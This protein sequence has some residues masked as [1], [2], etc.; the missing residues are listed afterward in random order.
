[1][2]EKKQVKIGTLVD[3]ISAILN[4]WQLD[5]LFI[6]S[7]VE[8]YDLD[9]FKAVERATDI[10]EKISCNDVIYWLLQQKADKFI[11]DNKDE[12]EKRRINIEALQ[13]ELQ[14]SIFTNAIDSGFD[15]ENPQIQDL[16]NEFWM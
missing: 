7:L 2:T 16:L 9:I 4:C 8:D 12:L 11:E 15:Y 1:M 13:Q 3:I 6:A 14:D 5:S 10:S